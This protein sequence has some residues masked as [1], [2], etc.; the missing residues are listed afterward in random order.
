M[1]VHLLLVVFAH[2]VAWALDATDILNVGNFAA[3]LSSY[4]GDVT[5]WMGTLMA[6]V[7]SMGVWL[8]VSLLTACL[9]V[10]VVGLGVAA[11]VKF[12][13]MIVSLFTGGGGN[14]A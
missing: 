13:R 11:A 6:D 7:S 12:A 14:A 4:A 3:T 9:T 10:A 2:L 1:V 8:P 5:G